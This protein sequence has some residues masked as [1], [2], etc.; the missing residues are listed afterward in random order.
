MGGAWA[1]RD[2]LEVAM[3]VLDGVNDPMYGISDLATALHDLHAF[4]V[5]QLD[6]AVVIARSRSRWVCI[7]RF[8]AFVFHVAASVLPARLINAPLRILASRLVGT[9]VSVI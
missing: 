7:L 9:S 2:G 1:I 8:G 5:A 6:A 4:E 3:T